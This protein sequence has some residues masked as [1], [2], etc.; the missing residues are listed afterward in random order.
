MGKSKP[1]NGTLEEN[2]SIKRRSRRGRSTS[3]LEVDGDSGSGLESFKSSASPSQSESQRSA[4]DIVAPTSPMLAIASSSPA[5]PLLEAVES[6]KPK[7]KA[8][9]RLTVRLFP[10]LFNPISKTGL[11]KLEAI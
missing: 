6:E 1:R 7:E 9:A 11:G 10:T 5:T 2:N 4:E 3:S 8:T